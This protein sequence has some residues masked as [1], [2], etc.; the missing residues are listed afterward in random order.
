LSVLCRQEV[1]HN[2]NLNANRS[3]HHYYL[4]LQAGRDRPNSAEI[5]GVK[6]FSLLW[7]PGVTGMDRACRPPD[8]IVGRQDRGGRP[9]RSLLGRE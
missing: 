1:F 2:H 8:S 3:Q 9:P 7:Q 5:Q 4:L 6:G